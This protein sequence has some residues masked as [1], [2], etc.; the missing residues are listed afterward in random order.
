MET[1][2]EFFIQDL[3]KYNTKGVELENKITANLRSLLIVPLFLRKKY[4]GSL[5]L[6]DYSGNLNLNEHQLNQIKIIGDYVAGSIES[7]FLLDEL[8]KTND[9]IQIERD[10]IVQNQIKLESLHKFNRRINSYSQL[11]DIT[12]EVFLYLKQIFNVELGFILLTDTKQN[13]LI[14]F[15]TSTDIF[16]KGLLVS[17]FLKNFRVPIHPSSGTLYRTFTKQKPLYLHK[18]SAWTNLSK[19]DM[20]I[21]SSFKLDSFAQIPLVVQGST[22]GIIC[23]TRL[24]SEM[25][26][27]KEEFKEISSFGEQVAGAIHNANLRRDL[28]FEAR[29]NKKIY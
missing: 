23:V 27:T 22:I 6:L 13:Q 16:N 24:T 20:E 5:D 4:I 17:N 14:P 15:Q 2:T 7:G 25:D 28:E 29:K 8:K 9:E 21:V 1:K 26:W 12:R 19:I 10:N 11:E 3:D 18:S